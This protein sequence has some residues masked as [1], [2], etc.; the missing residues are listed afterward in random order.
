MSVRCTAQ[1]KPT[2]VVVARSTSSSARTARDR[3]LGMVL[4]DK[5]EQFKRVLS[6]QFLVVIAPHR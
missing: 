6:L 3:S 1:V 5:V 2:A 4:S